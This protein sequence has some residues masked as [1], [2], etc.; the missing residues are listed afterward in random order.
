MHEIFGQNTVPSMTSDSDAAVVRAH[1]EQHGTV[2][3]VL[4]LGPWL[5]AL[6]LNFASVEEVHVVDN[7]HWTKD[8]DRRVPNLLQRDASK[9]PVV[10]KHAPPAVKLFEMALENVSILLR[11]CAPRPIRLLH[12]QRRRRSRLHE[13]SFEFLQCIPSRLICICYVGRG[14]APP[15]RRASSR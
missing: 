1:L 4:E 5:G 14:R 9:R 6:T 8:H 7:F 15:P 12:L 2:R 13:A 3:R 11:S 10:I